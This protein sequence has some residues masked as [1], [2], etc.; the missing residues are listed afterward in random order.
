VS[1]EADEQVLGEVGEN[2]GLMKAFFP[3]RSI[4]Q[5]KRK[6]LRENA[7][8]PEK[9]TQAILAKKPIGEQWLILGAG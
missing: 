8:N 4:A 2:Y 6:G 9:V 7:K 5:I 1:R 3:G